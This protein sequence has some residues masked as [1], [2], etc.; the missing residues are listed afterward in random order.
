MKEAPD[1]SCGGE[2]GTTL[3]LIFLV[4]KL[5]GVINWSW[6]WVCAPLWIPVVAVLAIWVVFGIIALVVFGVAECMKKT[7]TRA[8]GR[9]F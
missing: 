6:L 9:G 1:I 7:K 4:L 8:G 3:F 5:I 2:I